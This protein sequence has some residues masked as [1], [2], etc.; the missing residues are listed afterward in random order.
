[1]GGH[2]GRPKYFR[3]CIKIVFEN[4]L[5]EYHFQPAMDVR[6]RCAGL[7]PARAGAIAHP[8]AARPAEA[9]PKNEYSSYCSWD[10]E[11]RRFHNTYDQL[12]RLLTKEV[13]VG[14]STKVPQ[15]LCAASHLLCYPCLYEPNRC[16]PGSPRATSGAFRA[17][18]EPS[19][20]IKSPFFSPL[21]TAVYRAP[22]FCA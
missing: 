6:E 11:D 19:T 4:L 16:A 8:V 22:C 17:F 12:Q 2:I 20:Y 1:L 7:W 15:H 3:Q 9:R 5:P 21:E 18:R 10:T 13:T 14:G